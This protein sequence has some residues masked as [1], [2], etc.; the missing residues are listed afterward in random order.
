M[1]AGLGAIGLAFWS[2][3][4]ENPFNTRTP[5]PPTRV[6]GA[7]ILPHAPGIVFINLRNAIAERNVVNYERCFSDSLKTG[8][9]FHF[10]PET[11]VDNAR[12]GLFSNWSVR[13]ER[14]YFTRMLDALPGDSLRSLRLDSLKTDN[15]TSNSVTYFQRY[16]LIVR[17]QLQSSGVPGKVSG[18]GQF[19]LIKDRFGEWSIYRWEDSASGGRLTWSTLKADFFSR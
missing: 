16:E 19:G 1:A 7:W 18:E 3:A 13:E 8:R 14:A 2:S 5:E 11:T 9:Q 10:K 6:Q 17:H 15:I 4:C 12:P